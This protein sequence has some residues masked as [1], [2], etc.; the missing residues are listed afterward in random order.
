MLDDSGEGAATVCL[1]S[2]F[3][4]CFRLHADPDL[5]HLYNFCVQFC[6]SLISRCCIEWRGILLI[7]MPVLC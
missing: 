6:R 2:H 4:I 1:L 3:Y 5:D 7:V